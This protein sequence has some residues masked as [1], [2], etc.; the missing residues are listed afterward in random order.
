MPRTKAENQRIREEQKQHILKAAI[1]VLAYKGIATT[2]MADIAAEANVSYGL[3]YHYFPNKEQVL[4]EL[5][6]WCMEE[7]AKRVLLALEQPGTPLEHF[8]QFTIAF[9][10]TLQLYPE[11]MMLIQQVLHDRELHAKFH[12]KKH[13]VAKQADSRMRASLRSQVIEGQRLGE[14]A[15]DDPDIL[16]TIYLACLRGLVTTAALHDCAQ[17]SAPVHIILRLLKA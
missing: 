4:D 1:K 13:T 16:V 3:V 11:F 7:N 17:L 10:Q 5:F 12:D 8:E 6:E 9:L 15:P 2:T 14:I